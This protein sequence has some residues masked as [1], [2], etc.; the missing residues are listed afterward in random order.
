M[1][2][3]ICECVF[4]VTL[5]AETPYNYG[6]IC[7]TAI[8]EKHICTHHMCILH[9]DLCE[10]QCTGMQKPDASKHVLQM[11]IQKNP[12]KTNNSTVGFLVFTFVSNKELLNS[13]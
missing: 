7:L 6:C 12:P 13:K 4:A 3:A 8:W 10:I 11:T 2:F 9:M 1:V 5:K